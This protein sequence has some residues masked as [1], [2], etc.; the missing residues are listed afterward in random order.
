ML[1][2]LN[3]LCR[4]LEHGNANDAKQMVTR[5]ISKNA[6]LQESIIPLDPDEEPFT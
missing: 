6:R 4:D 1:L 3:R 5:I 2:D